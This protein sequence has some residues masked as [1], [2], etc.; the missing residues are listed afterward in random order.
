[1]RHILQSAKR[2]IV[3]CLVTILL[4]N[5]IWL[6]S[7]APATAGNLTINDCSHSY[8]PQCGNT[9]SPLGDIVQ[10]IGYL[11]GLAGD[12][13]A[14]SSMG[15][16]SGL[17]GAGITSGLAAIGGLAGGGM[18][19][20]V[21]ATVAAPAVVAVATGVGMSYLSHVLS[22]DKANAQSEP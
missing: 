4:A 8:Q 16:V 19:M 3:M 13:A 18:V 21:A 9:E 12:I 11:A 7:P 10:G 20:G 14:I 2:L 5:S 15:A 22:A 17:S 6:S 1:M